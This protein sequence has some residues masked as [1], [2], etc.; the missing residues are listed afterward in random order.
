M[1]VPAGNPVIFDS[2]YQDPFAIQFDAS[3]GILY[4]SDNGASELDTAV[5]DWTSN[6]APGF[7]INRAM[8]AGQLHRC[9]GPMM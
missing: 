6:T 2:S 9:R 3:T 7:A 1:D 5:A 4:A 8:A